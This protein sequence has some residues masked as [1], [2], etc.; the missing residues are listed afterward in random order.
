[1]TARAPARS[2]FGAPQLASRHA[3]PVVL[4]AG[5][6]RALWPAAQRAVAIAIERRAPLVVLSI[7]PPEGTPPIDGDGPA[8]AYLDALVTRARRAGASAHYV[9]RR[10]TVDTAVELARTLDPQLVVVPGSLTAGRF[11]RTAACPVL[12]VQ[13]WT[14]CRDVLGEPGSDIAGAEASACT[15]ERRATR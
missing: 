10:G 3:A 13:W 1:M 15:P 9:V 11:A 4:I 7:T 6:S 12:T 2:R 5:R 8:A 14:P